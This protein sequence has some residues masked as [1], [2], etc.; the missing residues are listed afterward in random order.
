MDGNDAEH[1]TTVESNP[2]R[3]SFTVTGKRKTY[4]AV[5]ICR[6]CC[7]SRDELFCVC[8]ACANHC[9]EFHDEL[10]YIGMGMAYCD[11]SHLLETGCKLIN[12]SEKDARELNIPVGSVITEPAPRT[13]DGAE[14]YITDSFAIQELE[15][16]GTM[17]QK[18]MQQ[19]SELIKHSRE[20]F[21]LHHSMDRS[22]WT[23]LEQLAWCVFQQNV[24]HYEIKMEDAGGAEWWVQV[25]YNLE[26][27]E[28]YIAEIDSNG[29][30]VDDYTNNGPGSEA[31]DLHYDKDETLAEMFGLGSFPTL[32]TV[33][34][35]TSSSNPTIIL[36][37]VYEQEDDD[38]ISEM[39]VSHPK[40]GKHLV[41]DGKLL[42]GAPSHADLRRFYHKS[43]KS[44]EKSHLRVTLLVNIWANRKPAGVHSLSP[45]IQDSV[46]KLRKNIELTGPLHLVKWPIETM[47]LEDE[48]WEGKKER[49]ERI[50]LPFV[51]KGITWESEDDESSGLVVV[52]FPPAPHCSDTIRMRFGAGMQAY[53]DHSLNEQTVED[54]NLVLAGARRFAYEDAYI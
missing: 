26:S 9:H 3:C 28:S 40:R 41:F 5:F 20:T 11:C 6:T 31:V 38:V 33:T 37:H 52:T 22:K 39:V 46:K 27:E 30:H 25:K 1:D 43:D 51:C 12:K 29:R 13:G 45:T 36:N 4:Q 35:L 34:Y 44:E 14:G 10:D 47:E 19:A 48:G 23:D 21:W 49:K 7:D 24:T 18:I 16:N 32:S 2:C 15:E 53:M 54:P 8:E 50:E 17:C 42:H